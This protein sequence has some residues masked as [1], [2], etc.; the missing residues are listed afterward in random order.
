[1]LNFGQDVLY[2]SQSDI[3]T[4]RF[5]VCIR[6]KDSLS[7]IFNVFQS[8]LD[9]HNLSTHVPKVVIFKC[10]FMCLTGYLTTLF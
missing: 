9:L 10:L 1:M 8:S 6:S 5:V 2:D 3:D 4:Y 7:N